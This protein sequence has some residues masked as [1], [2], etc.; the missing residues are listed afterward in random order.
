MRRKKSVSI[1]TRDGLVRFLQKLQGG[2]TAELLAM[3]FLRCLPRAQYGMTCEGHF[4]LGKELYCHFTSPIR[5]YPDLF[6]HQQLLA[7]DMGLPLRDNAFLESVVATCNE[8]EL[9]IDQA[10]FAALDRMKLRFLETQ[11]AESPGQC[12]EAYVLKATSDGLSLFLPETGLVSFLEKE[13]MNGHWFFDARK[14]TLLNR[15]GQGFRC[16]DVMYVQIRDIDP[17]H[18]DL[19]L[20]PAQLTV[21]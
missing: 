18:G 19:T 4:G 1:G 12:Y 6:V 20:R 2:T 5:R 9:N 14:A 13:H 17:I 16:G 10:G 3:S 21:V 8:Q 7:K 15:E 11:R